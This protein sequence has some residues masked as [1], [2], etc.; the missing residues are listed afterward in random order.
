[1]NIDV[2]LAPRAAKSAVAV[3]HIIK[4]ELVEGAETLFASGRQPFTTPRIDIDTLTWSRQAPGPAFDVPLKEIFEVLAATGERLRADP[5]GYVAEALDRMTETCT[6]ERRIVE[7][8]YQEDLPQMFQDREG[9]EYML[10]RELGS[11]EVLDFWQ[12]ARLANGYELRVRAFPPRMLH[13]LAGNVPAVAASAIIKGALT[14]GVHLL[15]MPSNDLFTAP[16]IL[17][18]MAAAVP[19]IRS[20]VPSARYTGA[21]VTPKSRAASA[22]RSSFTK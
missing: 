2:N 17:K 22:I 15:K 7:D 20:C 11:L 5:D 3:Q 10:K 16:A 8:L 9:L 18:T 19:T 13:V 1:M 6:L 21:A 14:K 4:G 12:L